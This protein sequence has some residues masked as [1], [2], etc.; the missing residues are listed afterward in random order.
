MTSRLGYARS[1]MGGCIEIDR[2]LTLTGV[3]D[4]KLD[5]K[6]LVEMASRLGVFTTFALA[7]A[8]FNATLTL[9][10]MLGHLAPSPDIEIEGLPPKSLPSSVSTAWML[11]AHSAHRVSNSR[12]NHRK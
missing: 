1:R 2:A 12:R 6:N 10:F 9:F 8:H 3:G 5:Q 11:T 7:T 4:I